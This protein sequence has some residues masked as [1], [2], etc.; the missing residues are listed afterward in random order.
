MFMATGLPH[1]RITAQRRPQRPTS[2]S[3]VRDTQGANLSAKSHQKLP[4]ARR[5]E[6]LRFEP[7]L[8][9]VQ[10][11]GKPV[12]AEL[13][14]SRRQHASPSN[15]SSSINFLRRLRTARIH[16]TP[17]RLTAGW[18]LIVVTTCHASC[19]QGGRMDSS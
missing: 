14:G 19:L 9:V 13:A 15:G 10:A 5:P 4:Y 2:S 12:I 3:K 6:T 7:D 8:S 11:I 18:W 16:L 17:R 1:R